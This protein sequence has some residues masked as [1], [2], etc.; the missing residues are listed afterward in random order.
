MSNLKIKF[1]TSCSDFALPKPLILQ[2]SLKPFSVVLFCGKVI[3]W[4]LLWNSKVTTVHTFPY[5][6]SYLN[7]NLKSTNF[8]SPELLLLPPPPLPR[9]RIPWL[10][11]K[12]HL[13][14]T[15]PED[16]RTAQV[17]WRGDRGLPGREPH[18][19]AADGNLRPQASRR[20]RHRDRVTSVV[21]NC[22][23]LL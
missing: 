2:D 17:G 19:T 9:E 7:T 14:Q 16:P 10:R 20:M 15:H 23:Y 12:I 6:H 13:P 21:S 8:S 3:Q 1:R 5:S 4:N 11:S 22:K 18:R